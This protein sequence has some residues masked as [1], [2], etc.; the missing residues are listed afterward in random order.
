MRSALAAGRP[1]RA[2]R[3]DLEY[4]A[5]S[6]PRYFMAGGDPVMSAFTAVLS[7]F[8]P[9]GEDY[10][11]RSVRSYR[12][13][14]EDAE[15]RARV[16][17]FIGQEAMHGREH[18]RFNTHLAARGY[19]TRAIDR[20]VRWS[21]KL[22]ESVPGRSRRLAA[23]A[24]F[25]HYTATWAELFLR[26]AAVRAT[27]DVDEVR[28][29]FCWH[30]LEEC[31]HKDVAF[32]VYQ[33]AVGDERIRRWTMNAV[34]VWFVSMLASWMAVSLLIDG[35]TYRHP[36]RVA[37][38][39]RELARSPFLSRPFRSRVRDY[40]RP[41]FHPDDHD[42]SELLAAWEHRLFGTTG[43]LAERLSNAEPAPA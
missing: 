27:A 21:A 37:R 35:N 19:P 26:D 2:R 10:F 9:E 12:D 20:V 28:Q 22:S 14:I 25:E 36:R 30:A 38:G 1:I 41:G 4:P 7:A 11:V 23:T 42:T 18:R 8:F 24:A 17:G 15:L 32:D 39:L 40:N 34:T 29:L 33:Q 13:A 31:E 16:A 43:E 5:D 3:I 6:L